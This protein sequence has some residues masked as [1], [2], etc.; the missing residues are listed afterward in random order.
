MVEKVNLANLVESGNY[1][2]AGSELFTQ[3][4]QIVTNKL[5]IVIYS[6]AKS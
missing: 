2:L 1:S 5:K 3:I 6:V 4:V